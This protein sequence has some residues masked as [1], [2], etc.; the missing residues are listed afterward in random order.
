MAKIVECVPNFSDGRRPEVIDAIVKAMTAVKGCNLLA[1][2]M[3]YDHNRSV[4][5]VAGEPG[6][7]SDGVFEGVKKAMELIDL[8]DHSGEH[9]RMGATDVVPFVPISGMKMACT[10]LR[11]AESP[12]CGRKSSSSRFSW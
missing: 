7:V 8:N 11:S 9:P 12:M 2:E 4:V 10:S 6:P 5:T 1:K 3:D